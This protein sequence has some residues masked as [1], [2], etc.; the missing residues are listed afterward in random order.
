MNQ[1]ETSSVG[2][3]ETIGQVERLYRAVTGSD[4][5]SPDVAYAPIPAEKDPTQHVEEQVNRLLEL[6]GQ[7]KLG[8]DDGPSWIPTV[9]VWEAD[10]EVLVCIDLPGLRRENVEVVAQGNILTVSGSRPASREGLRL[11]S[12][13]GGYGRF[14]RVLFV[15]GGIRGPEPS[16]QMREGV[17]EIRFQRQAQ[18][19]ATPRPVA[20]H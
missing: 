4:A 19:S 17:L 11:R 18:A 20:V 10:A 13:E 16:A 1:S 2:I 14:R 3:D 15:P 9:S 12:S 7:V 6:L 5:P 8:P